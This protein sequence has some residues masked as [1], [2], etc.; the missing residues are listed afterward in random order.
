MSSIGANEV[1]HRELAGAALISKHH[2]HERA[3][4]Q[5]WRKFWNRVRPFIDK[6]VRIKDL[7]RDSWPSVH[8][9]HT[10]FP[11]HLTLSFERTS[12]DNPKRVP[13]QELMRHSPGFKLHRER[14]RRGVVNRDDLFEHRWPLAA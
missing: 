10:A 3:Q 9:Y 2:L 14:L 4:R 5:I 8:R 1:D 7:R 11:N 12:G 13:L 6:D